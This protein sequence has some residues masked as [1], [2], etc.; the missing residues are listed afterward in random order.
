MYAINVKGSEALAVL[1]FVAPVSQGAGSATTGWISVAQFQKLLAIIQ[2]GVMGASA[3]LDAKF[4]QANT[5]AGGGAKDVAVTAITQV[6][7]ASGDNKIVLVNL[8]AQ[9]LDVA[10]GFAWVQLSVTDAVAA[11]L[12]SAVVLGLIPRNA[13]ADALNNAAVVQVVN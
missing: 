5:S 6:V 11:S 8:D 12:I 1:D 7:K 2:T 10:N 3:T 4:Q 9:Q 13:S